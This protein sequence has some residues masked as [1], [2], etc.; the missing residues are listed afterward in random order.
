[1]RSVFK[2][3][4]TFVS[5]ELSFGCHKKVF[6][7]FADG[8]L[9]FLTRVEPLASVRASEFLSFL[10]RVQTQNKH[11]NKATKTHLLKNGLTSCA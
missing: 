9:V 11:S 8:G 10:V 3:R 5:L 4:R 6:A 1:M 2:C 7:N